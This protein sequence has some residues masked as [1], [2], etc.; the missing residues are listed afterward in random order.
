M[1][2]TNTARATLPDDFIVED[3]D[4]VVSPVRNPVNA[5]KD[6]AGSIHDDATAQKLGFRGGTVAGSLHM[7]QFAPLMTH[8]FGDNWFETGNL[9]LY[10]RFATID[11]EGVRCFANQPKERRQTSVWMER[12]DGKLVLSGTAAF[13]VPDM[14]SALRSRIETAH[15][16]GDQRIL[17]D[18]KIGNVSGDFEAR[19]KSSRL[20]ERLQNM[21]E[22]LPVYGS[23]QDA[24]V[25]PS[26]TVHLMR[27]VENELIHRSASFGVGLFGAIELQYLDGPVRVGE[28]YVAS[29]RVLAVGETAQTEYFWYE[30]TLSV[31]TSRTPTAR[32]LMMLRFMKS[33]SPLW[34]K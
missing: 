28:D 13:G 5:S 29:G 10:F 17:R 34:Q 9:S 8:I 11:G 26:E 18:V 16:R 15:G 22:P 4:V 21:V 32:M 1:A 14:G 31:A 3:G 7:D 20:E 30:S 6:E 2:S 24:V 25:P 12:D 19:V 23:L 33:S 27:V